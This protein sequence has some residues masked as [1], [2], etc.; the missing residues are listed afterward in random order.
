MELCNLFVALVP[1][2]LHTDTKVACRAHALSA[3]STQLSVD[4]TLWHPRCSATTHPGCR[5]VR[6]PENISNLSVLQCE[7]VLARALGWC[8]AEW[9]CHLLSNK[10]DSSVIVVYSP[11]E[12][13]FMFPLNWQ[14]H[15]VREGNFTV[16]SDSVSTGHHASKPARCQVLDKPNPQT[17]YKPFSSVDPK[18]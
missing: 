1:E 11:R 8:R 15:L 13:E 4:E 5:E 10:A 16:E 18:P 3:E 9:W 6:V 2:L 12:A 14:Q 17:L 7:S